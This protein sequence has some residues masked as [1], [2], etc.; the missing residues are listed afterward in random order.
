MIIRGDLIS[1]VLFISD[2]FISSYSHLSKSWGP[3]RNL[4]KSVK[5][6]CFIA[7]FLLLSRNVHPNPGPDYKCLSTPC[8]VKGIIYLNV[9]SLLPNLDSV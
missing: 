8:D 1:S 4:Q 5:R 7:L 3:R 2:W 6:K 9:R